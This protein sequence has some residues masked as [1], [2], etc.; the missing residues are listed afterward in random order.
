MRITSSDLI[1]RLQRSLCSRTTNLG[2]LRCNWHRACGRA[3][4]EGDAF[5][6]GKASADFGPVNWLIHE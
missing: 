1:S 3:V 2:R 6:D 4:E 5:S